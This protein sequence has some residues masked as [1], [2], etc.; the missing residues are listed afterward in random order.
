[1]SFYH[2]GRPIQ[3]RSL[4]TNTLFMSFIVGH[5]LFPDPFPH[6]EYKPHEGKISVVPV[7]TLF[8]VS[9]VADTQC[10]LKKS[11]RKDYK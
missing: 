8:A 11:R 4:S 5:T 3:N 7:N 6:Q 2:F 1:M 9:G 10:L